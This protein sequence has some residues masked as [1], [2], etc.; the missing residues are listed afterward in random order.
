MHFG[1]IFDFFLFFA[2]SDNHCG[3]GDAHCNVLSMNSKSSKMSGA[4]N[5]RR[6]IK[7]IVAPSRV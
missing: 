5:P 6:P 3:E 1:L 4:F 2:S 7:L